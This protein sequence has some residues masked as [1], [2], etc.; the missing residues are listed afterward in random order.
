MLDS[1]DSHTV[2]RELITAGVVDYVERHAD[3]KKRKREVEMNEAVPHTEPRGSKVRPSMGEK[4]E[5][6]KLTSVVKERK[7]ARVTIG[8]R[9]GDASILFGF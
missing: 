9:D 7:R 2:H 4:K 1:N 6:M 3:N 5:T 8:T